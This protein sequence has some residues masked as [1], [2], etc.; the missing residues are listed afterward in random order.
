MR[1]GEFL[2]TSCGKKEK[3]RSTQWEE[4]GVL[5]ISRLGPFAALFSVSV[6]WS[7]K[8]VGGSRGRDNPVPFT[9]DQSYNVR[10]ARSCGWTFEGMSGKEEEE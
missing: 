5:S 6:P 3:R 9:C 4:R 1:D 2:R 7:H 8:D 10:F